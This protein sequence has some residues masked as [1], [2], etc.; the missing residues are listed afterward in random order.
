[1]KVLYRSDNIKNVC[2]R[3]DHTY[4]DRF[5]AWPEKLKIYTELVNLYEDEKNMPSREEVNII[6]GNNTWTELKCMECNIDV[7]KLIYL[8]NGYER[9]YYICFD[10]LKKATLLGHK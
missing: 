7:E 10:C 9:F 6:I 1:M 2:E 5:V 4:R 8:D 3:W